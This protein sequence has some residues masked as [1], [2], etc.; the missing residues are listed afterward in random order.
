MGNVLEV[1]F[2]AHPCPECE[3]NLVMV[4]DNNGYWDM[5]C[6]CG[7]VIILE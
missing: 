6:L 4:Y 1:S 7:S 2:G 5:I 3:R